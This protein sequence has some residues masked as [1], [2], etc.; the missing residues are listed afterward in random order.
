MFFITIGRHGAAAD[1][2]GIT[3]VLE[4]LEKFLL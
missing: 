2:P 1:L 4:I 3:E